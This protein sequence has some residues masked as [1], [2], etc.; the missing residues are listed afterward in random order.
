MSDGEAPADA[1]VRQVVPFLWV[2]D[3]ARSLRFYVDGLGF[4]MKN[5]WEVDG[6]VRWCWLELGGSALMLQELAQGGH[7]AGR[8]EGALGQG[9][10]LCLM[11]R[12]AIAIYRELLSRGIAAA[13]PQVGNALWVTD[14]TDPDG[15]RLYFESPTDVPEETKLS[16]WAS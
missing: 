4:A 16:E 8:P 15:Y 9:V 11:C 1:N 14:V 6:R 7:H 3:L 13:E 5:R 10:S 2:T 12:D